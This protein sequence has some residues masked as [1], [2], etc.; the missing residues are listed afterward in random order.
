MRPHFVILDWVTPSGDGGGTLPHT[1]SPQIAGPEDGNAVAA[2]AKEKALAGLQTTSEPT[3]A[4][5]MNDQ[6]PW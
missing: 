5:E 6:I 4:E 2:P 3:L 1:S